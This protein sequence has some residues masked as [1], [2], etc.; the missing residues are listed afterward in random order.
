MTGSC[1][2][3]DIRTQNIQW[4]LKLCQ[5]AHS[6]D[7]C[8]SKDKLYAEMAMQKG[9]SKKAYEEYLSILLKNDKIVIDG[10]E[11]MLNIKASI[12]N[13]FENA[14]LNDNKKGSAEIQEEPEVA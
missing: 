11:L 8:L 3:Q 10:D 12:E 5:K 6:Q 13:D 7:K 4:I 14:G 2:T 1:W 9:V